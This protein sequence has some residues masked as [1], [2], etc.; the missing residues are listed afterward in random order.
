MD[1]YHDDPALSQSIFASPS[2]KALIDA[3]SSSNTS[4]ASQSRHPRRY[5]SHV[6]EKTSNIRAV[7]DTASK[8]PS[9]DRSGPVLKDLFA[10]SPET[11]TVTALTIV[12]DSIPAI[13]SEITQWTTQDLNLIVTTG[14]TGF[15]IRDVTP[16]VPPP[17]HNTDTDCR[18]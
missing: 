6:N 12:P 1:D 4:P 17:L 3:V 5:I 16:E 10:E 7:S 2:S 18:H 8:D 15:A 13:Q 14:G 9:T 11:W